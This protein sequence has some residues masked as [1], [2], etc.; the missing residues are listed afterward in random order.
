MSKEQSDIKL[1]KR[2]RENLL[3]VLRH[4]TGDSAPLRA[5]IILLSGAGYSGEQIAQSVGVS[6]R[7]VREARSRWRSNRFKGLSDSPR[8]GR[9]NQADS[10]YIHLLIRTSK[11]NPH[12]MGYVFSRWTAPRL[13]TYMNEKTGV[14]LSPHYIATLLQMHRIVWGKSKLTINNLCDPNEKKIGREMVKTSTKG[15]RNAQYMF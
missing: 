10:D 9:P 2:D 6:S 5:T 8:S 14:K 13:S 1:T 3:H 7:T 11:R 4:G 15:L 12:N